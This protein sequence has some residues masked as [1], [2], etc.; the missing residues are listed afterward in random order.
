M[1]AARRSAAAATLVA[2]AL[3]VA[4]CGLFGDDASTADPTTSAPDRSTTSTTSGAGEATSP[5]VTLLDAGA[6]PRSTLRV[7]PH[8]G[9][10]ATVVFTTDL[11]VQQQVSG[12]TQRL[13][14]P[15]ISETMRITVG[16]VTDSGAQMT[17]VL[18]DVA[19]QRKGSGLT[20]QQADDLDQELGTLVG[21]R[22]EGTMRPDGSYQDLQ[23]HVPEGASK[24]VQAQ[25]DD[26]ETAIA[27]LNP[28][29]PAEP[30]GLGARWRV[31]ATTAVGGI[32][33]RATTTYEI[34]DLGDDTVAYAAAISIEAGAQPLTRGL[35][36]G[37]TARLVRSRQTGSGRGVMGLT[38][39]EITLAMQTKGT[40]TVEVTSDGE[41]ATVDQGVSLATSARTASS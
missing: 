41:T 3:L 40:Q 37:T 25:V 32:E 17:M 28:P 5:Q 24:A 21:L 7:R 11:A 2:L 22:A 12:R 19:V 6:E 36:E 16:T 27:G 10:R 13:D 33:S 31:E 34:T 29:L 8:E 39:P 15:P 4:G 26:L 14:S 1:T 35:P 20:D 9:D 23:L 18:D 38:S 30:V